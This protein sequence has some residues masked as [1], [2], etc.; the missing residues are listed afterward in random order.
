MAEAT[1]AQ[2]LHDALLAAM[3]AGAFHEDA[4]SLCPAATRETAKEAAPVS[5]DNRTFTEAEHLA[6]LTDRVARETADLTEAKT[7]LETEVS[8][9][10]QR[11][12]VLE[13][14][15]AAA[16]TERDNTKAEF[17]GFKKDLEEKAA[18][19]ER[20][21]ARVARVKAANE[22]LPE[23]YFTEERAT[24]WAEMAD[25]AFDAFVADI[26]AVKVPT[27]TA[28]E[29]AAFTGGDSPTAKSE[30]S[31]LGSFLG[32]RHAPAGK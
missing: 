25:E 6:L 11:V 23:D 12:D 24:R 32:L 17:E 4:C 19:A 30:G 5:D 28:R 26:E 16:I 22:S 2:A 18:V 29:T 27:T 15:K 1:A 21:E 14:E 3:P 13:A 10:K 20:K 7:A 9:L 8:E 31:V